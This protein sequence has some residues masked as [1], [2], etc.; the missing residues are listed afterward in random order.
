[1][2]FFCLVGFFSPFGLVAMGINLVTDLEKEKK[3]KSPGLMTN[4]SLSKSL[5]DEA[6]K[7]SL[8]Y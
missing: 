6:S 8:Y 5:E 1:M 4:T 7:F 3:K 2:G